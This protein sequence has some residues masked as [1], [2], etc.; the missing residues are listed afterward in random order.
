[1]SGIAAGNRTLELRDGTYAEV[2]VVIDNES[3][4]AERPIRCASCRESW[5]A[6]DYDTKWI[7]S[8]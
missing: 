5:C 3:Y 2:A 8:G 6:D 7:V 1:M 4:V